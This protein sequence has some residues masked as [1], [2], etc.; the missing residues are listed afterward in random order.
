MSN[1]TLPGTL[2][3]FSAPSGA[4]KTSLVNGLLDQTDNLCVSI[5]HTTRPPRPGELHGKDYFFIDIPAFEAMRDDGQFLEHARVF[6]NYYGTAAAT[7]DS[8]LKQGTDTILEIDWQGAE[9]V[10]KLYPACVSIF[11]IP[12]SR[13]ELENRLKSRGQ[14]DNSVI[15]RRMRDA[16]NE[17]AHYAAFDY[18]VIND[19]FEHALENLKAIVLAQ[20]QRIDRQVR[21]QEQLLQQL[22]S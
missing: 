18:L 11:I 20:R 2:Y 15:A 13:S 7:V 16:A 10:R 9:Q 3:I 22:L 8:Q 17:I 19:D 1:Q 4:G 5:S 14:D 21:A 6:D 12:P